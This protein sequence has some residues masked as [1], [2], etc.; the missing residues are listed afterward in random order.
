M[1][2]LVKPLR[3]AAAVAAAVFV[4]VSDATAT[5]SVTC[6]FCTGIGVA[7]ATPAGYYEYTWAPFPGYASP[8]TT[9]VNWTYIISC[10]GGLGSGVLVRAYDSAHVQQDV[11][12]AP[13]GL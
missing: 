13:C 6:S 7:T 3:V 10:N 4:M 8:P 2:T 12:A 5:L 1:K 11:G 9:N